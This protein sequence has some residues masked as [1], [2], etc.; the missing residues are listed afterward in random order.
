MSMAR[1]R[2]F[3]VTAIGSDGWDRTGASSRSSVAMARAKPPVKH[4]PTAPT[5]RPGVR[6]ARSLAT[7]LQVLR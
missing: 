7:A 6:A 3:F 2:S 4:M 1:L 5:P